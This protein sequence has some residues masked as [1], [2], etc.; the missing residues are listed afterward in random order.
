MHSTLVVGGLVLLLLST[1]QGWPD[2]LPECRVSS[3]IIKLDHVVIAVKDL[4]SASQTYRQLGFTAK[5]G[6]RHANGLLNEHLKFRDGTQ[7]ELMSVVGEAKDEIA[8][9]Y[10]RFLLRGEGGAYLAMAGGQQEVLRAA[11]SVGVAAEPLNAGRLRYVTFSES[12]LGALFF[13][14]STLRVEDPDSIFRHANGA[15]GIRRVWLEASPDLGD[16]LSALGAEKCDS[17]TVPDGREGMVYAVG[18]GEVVLVP[19]QATRARV[20]G[21]VLKS[22][23]SHRDRTHGP[24][25]THGIWLA[26][27]ASQR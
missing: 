24:G 26:L 2:S 9:G 5:A 18:G 1:P 10:E 14:E 16:L 3:A 19:P 4:E 6:R 17:V 21:A 27:P 23:G 12:A 15:E 13:V 25:E 22:S 20:L 7:L 8:R 11:A